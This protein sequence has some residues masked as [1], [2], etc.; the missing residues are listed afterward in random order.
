M[1][2]AKLLGYISEI[3]SKHFV[4]FDNSSILG[5]MVDNIKYLNLFV[6]FTLV[7]RA[8]YLPCLHHYGQDLLKNSCE[9]AGRSVTVVTALRW[10]VGQLLLEHL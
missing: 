2:K 1:K 10:R 5:V 7:L 9:I 4:L 8:L 3:H 6:K